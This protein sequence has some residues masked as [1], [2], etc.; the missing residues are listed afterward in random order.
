MSRLRLLTNRP[1]ELPG[2]DAFG[3]EIDEHVPLQ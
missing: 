1:K 3:L 2:L